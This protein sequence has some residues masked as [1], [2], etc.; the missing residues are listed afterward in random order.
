[1]LKG[2]IEKIGMAC[3]DLFAINYDLKKF[4]KCE[5]VLKRGLS[6][7]ELFPGIKNYSL[8]YFHLEKM[9]VELRMR[10]KKEDATSLIKDYDQLYLKAKEALK[11]ALSDSHLYTLVTCMMSCARN[12]QLLLGK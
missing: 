12:K 4:E 7:F 3:T 6:H 8:V 11:T 2:Y 5:E 9:M 1:M 10:Y